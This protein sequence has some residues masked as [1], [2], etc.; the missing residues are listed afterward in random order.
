MPPDHR[1]YPYLL[2][3]WCVTGQACGVLP[4]LRKNYPFK[5]IVDIFLVVNRFRYKKVVCLESYFL[6]FLADHCFCHF[7]RGPGFNFGTGP[8]LGSQRPCGRLEFEP[9][10]SKLRRVVVSLVLNYN[11]LPLMKFLLL[12]EHFRS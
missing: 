5:S 2:N 7:C 9:W 1:L 11:L 10:L 4:P 6:S 8:G 3:P 12:R